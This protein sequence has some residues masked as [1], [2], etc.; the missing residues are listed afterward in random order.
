[1]VDLISKPIQRVKKAPVG[2]RFTIQA[3]LKD[4]DK[5]LLVPF[6]APTVITPSR[7]SIPEKPITE[8]G[9]ISKAIT[10][11]KKIANTPIKVGDREDAEVKLGVDIG[12]LKKV[13]QF[14]IDVL[15]EIPRSVLRVVLEATEQAGITNLGKIETKELG[16]E[17]GEAVLGKEP[18]EKFGAFGKKTLEA[19]GAKEE[20]AGKF[21]IPVGVAFTLVDFIP[22]GKVG[23]R[24]LKSIA[25]TDKVDD[26]IK[27]IGKTKVLKNIDETDKLKLANQLVDKKTVQ[28]VSQSIDNF[29]KNVAQAGKAVKAV[30]LTA[31]DKITEAIKKAKP[32]RKEQEAI[33]TAERARQTARIAAVGKRVKGEKGFFAQLG[34]LKGK[35]SK[36]QFE[37]IRG[38][39]KQTD[40]DDLFNTIEKADDL[41][42]F[43]KI[44]TKGSLAKL[45]D[46]SI[47]TRN[48]MEL[49]R[50]IFPGELAGEVLKKLPLSKKVIQGLAEVLNV[51]RAI[52]ASFDLSAPFRQGMFLIGRPK[53]FS[54]AFKDMF[55]YAF[56]NKAYQGLIDN[57]KARPTYKLMKKSNL[58][59]TEVG[60]V[61]LS[62]REEAFM[63]SLAE[64]IPLGGKIVKAS[65]RAYTGFLNKLRADVFD[66]LI[67]KAD[68]LGIKQTDK[69]VDDMSR[70]I[71]SATGRGSLG[72][73]DKA[74][75]AL[76]TVFFSPKLIASRVNLL[77]PYF[78]ATLDPF[79]RKEA[80]KSLLTFGGV[81]GTTFGLS[82]MGGLSV[83]A[84]PR[85][86]D[87][88]KIKVGNTRYDVLGGFQQYIRLAGQFISGEI[89]SSTSGRTM[90]L[91][92]GY[93]PMTRKDILQRFFENKLSPVASFVTALAS[94]KT[95]I[96]QDVRV[97]AE[98]INRFIPMV[99]QDM[100]DLFQ[101]KGAKGILQSLPAIFGVGV[102]TYGKQELIYGK[103][104]LRQPTA[105]IRP[106]LGLAETIAEKTIGKEPLIKSRAF[107]VE[108]FYDQL[109][110][111]PREEAAE[112]FN[113][114]EKANPDL[115]DKLRD[116]VRER[117]AG[118]TVEDKDLKS[119][120]VQSGAR[121]FAIKKNLDKLGAKEEKATLW[122]E[123]VEKGIITDA[124][125]D[126]LFIL[127]DDKDFDKP[128]SE[129]TPFETLMAVFK[130]LT[131]DPINVAKAVFTKEKLGKVEGKL[132][133]LQR[134]FGEPYLN[135]DGSLNPKGSAFLRKE[136]A[137]EFGIPESQ[138]PALIREHIVPV[139]AGGDNSNSNLQLIPTELHKSYTALD[140]ATGKAVKAGKLSRTEATEIMR[141]LKVDGKITIE[142]AFREI[143]YLSQQTQ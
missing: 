104:P 46:G 33:L 59:L 13:G 63:S 10:K 69:L 100:F 134:D 23:K 65:N 82:K 52:M 50:Q 11:I 37:P 123:Y 122:K 99:T 98:V 76:N 124:V 24:L 93:K 31:I 77:N 40:I 135:K 95:A 79:V 91:G 125:A 138:L 114:I 83:G 75:V 39:I 131:I 12:R 71:S 92:E 73:L 26:I 58:A 119:K 106:V 9:L 68:S 27:F 34:Q 54:S 86:A 80:L 102:Q 64:K 19:F 7:P 1:M 89:V 21:A 4:L 140:T 90:T 3:G 121:A 81:A 103:N 55:K 105:E 6:V 136:L 127:L 42:P 108:V 38:K 72:K 143:E 94:G 132:V 97:P 126:Q 112:I 8:K 22:G 74:S 116:I 41:L 47:P 107:N 30:K 139:S 45:L 137:R 129:R 110:N 48:E 15:R 28:E 117:E 20:I 84:D 101:E 85:N 115:A 56:S 49:L 113:E 53:R 128:V 32:L 60:S 44:T 87:F 78:Y 120:D 66:D 133:E 67:K 109:L 141:A 96:G 16:G 35:I 18:I 29:A 118:I 142:D 57:I 25:K 36:K 51:P 62:G 88:G 17:F 5:N 61:K 111:L 70:F 2:G 14:G 43:E 130:G